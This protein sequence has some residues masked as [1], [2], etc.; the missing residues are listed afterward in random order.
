VP[1]TPKARLV[2]NPALGQQLKFDNQLNQ[3]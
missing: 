1:R 3:A 2:P